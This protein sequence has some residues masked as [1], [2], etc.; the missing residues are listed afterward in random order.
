MIYSMLIQIF[1]AITGAALGGI[2]FGGLW[3]TVQKS[4]YFHHPALL[5]IASWLLRTIIVIAGFYFLTEGH[6]DRL[7]ACLIGFI[8]A[9]YAVIRITEKPPTCHQLHVYGANHEA[10]S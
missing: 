6:L 10:E 9:R 4:V 2:F 7:P 8:L 3:W 1:V 5:F